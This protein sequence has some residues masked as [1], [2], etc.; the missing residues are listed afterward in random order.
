MCKLTWI[1]RIN[2]Q[3]EDAWATLLGGG[4]DRHSRD[5][6]VLGRGDE[7]GSARGPQLLRFSRL[8][9]RMNER[10]NRSETNW[11]RNP[12]F[13]NGFTDRRSQM[14]L[15]QNA[16]ATAAVS[17]LSRVQTCATK[18]RECTTSCDVR[19]LACWHVD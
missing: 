6:T 5:R 17:R 18:H 12:R 8:E 7:A 9:T 10:N 1:P 15:S 4:H 2:G 11:I 13:S 19:S 3:S 16:V 14:P